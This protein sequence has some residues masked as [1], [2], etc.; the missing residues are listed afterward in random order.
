MKKLVSIV[1][2]LTIMFMNVIALAETPLISVTATKSN[3]HEENAATG[4]HTLTWSDWVVGGASGNW[5]VFLTIEVTPEMIDSGYN[6]KVYKNGTLVLA[7]YQLTSPQTIY[8][9]IPAQI[10]D[11]FIVEAYWD[12]TLC[13]CNPPRHP[14]WTTGVCNVTLA[15]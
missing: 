15:P 10:G 1:M 14:Y 2:I 7:V 12:Y 5:S 11:T 9:Y 4:S 6:A 13:I 8:E 3:L